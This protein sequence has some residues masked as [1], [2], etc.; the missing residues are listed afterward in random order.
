MTLL[1][2]IFGVGQGLDTA[3]LC[4]RA[5]LI[6]AYGLMLVRVAGRRMFGRWSALDIIV[7]IMVGSNLSRALTGN[8]PLWGTLAATTLLVLL[9]WLLARAAAWSPALSRLIEGRSITLVRDGRIDE[10]AMHLHGFTDA[11][12]REALRAAGID[13]AE[14]ARLLALEASGKVSVLKRE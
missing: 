13:R 2:S 11:D 10:R 6:F 3:Q 14:D 12:L 1:D 5:G 4:A 7:S 8:A 9:H